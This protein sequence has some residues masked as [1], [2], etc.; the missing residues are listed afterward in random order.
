[1]SSFPDTWKSMSLYDMSIQTIFIGLMLPTG[2][3]NLNLKTISPTTRLVEF[4]PR[5]G[6]SA[7]EKEA[8]TKQCSDEIANLIMAVCCVSSP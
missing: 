2:E 5:Y 7:T 6:I 1:M 8:K 3:S 4:D